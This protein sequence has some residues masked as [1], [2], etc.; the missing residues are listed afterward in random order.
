[1]SDKYRLLVFRPSGVSIMR[2]ETTDWLC[3]LQLELCRIGKFETS[4]MMGFDQPRIALGRNVAVR[5]AMDMECDYLLMVDPDM[6]PDMYVGQHPQAE[7]FFSSSLEWLECNG[8]GIVAAPAV[9]GRP[10]CRPNMYRMEDGDGIAHRYTHQQCRQ[11]IEEP[12]FEQVAAI[13]TGL[14]LI[15]MQVFDAIEK[16]W[17]HDLF[18]DDREDA[19]QLSQ[20]LYFTAGATQSGVPVWCN[21]FSW[22][23]HAQYEVL[24]CPGYAAQ[25]KDEDDNKIQMSVRDGVGSAA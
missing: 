20:D 7:L 5:N 17:F 18:V 23:G 8:P 1:M 6:Q 13:G 2:P 22:A 24:G 16:P 12:Q 9:S 14:M 3:R 25:V 4:T 10:L 15:N 19:L 11:A 21:W